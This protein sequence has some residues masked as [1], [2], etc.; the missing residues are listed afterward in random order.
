MRLKMKKSYE[1]TIYLKKRWGKFSRKPKRGSSLYPVHL[2][3]ERGRVVTFVFNNT[4]YFNTFQQRGHTNKLSYNNRL[5]SKTGNLANNDCV[6]N[7]LF[8]IRIVFIFVHYH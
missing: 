6:G 2:V 8:L 5:M 1:E 7:L 4:N 3:F